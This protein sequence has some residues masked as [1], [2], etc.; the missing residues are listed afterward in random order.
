MTVK[1]IYKR[2]VPMG[3]RNFVAGHPWVLHRR[4]H[5][6]V[7]A[8]LRLAAAARAA[9]KPDGKIR[10]TFVVQRPALWPNQK[11]VYEAMKADPAFEVSVIAIPK[12]PPAASAPDLVEYGRLMD[13]LAEKGIAFFMGYDIGGRTWINPLKFG[14]PDV[15]FLPQPYTQTQ[16]FLY[17]AS[18]LKHFC[19]VAIY[20]YGSTVD[21]MQLYLYYL[22]TYSDCHYIFMESQAVREMFAQF[23]PALAER[24]IVTGHPKL[25]VYQEPMPTDLRL[26]KVPAAKKR[27]IWAPHFTVTDDRT[28][29]TFSNFFEYY[30]FF[31][32]FVRN[33]P[34]IE[35]VLRPH[36]EL[37]EHMVATG[38]KTREEADAYRTRFNALP[39]GQVYEG[40]DIFTMFRQSDALILDCISFLAEYLPTGR[41]ICFLDGM[42]RQ[43]LNPIGERLLQTYY[44]AWNPEEIEDFIR[45]VVVGGDDYRRGEREQVAREYL[46]MPAG[47][48]GLAIKNRIK[49]EYICP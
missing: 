35:V 3:I 38:L 27:I 16:S 40:G 31:L 9:R 47:G 43:R 2:L 25:D 8:G 37:F 48:A 46:H 11:S 17:H 32:Q 33:H 12:I 29:H 18:H 7:R 6:L 22:P 20:N 28:P 19:K 4:N 15:V 23:A 39:N 34:E 5:H 42:R 13:F 24:L 10:V 21:D 36:P 41:P 30:D 26:W 14:L 44:I 1:Q 45:T 49:Q